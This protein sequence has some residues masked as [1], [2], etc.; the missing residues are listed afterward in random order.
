MDG[1]DQERFGRIVTLH[2]HEVVEPPTLVGR[3]PHDEGGGIPRRQGLQFSV[4]RLTSDSPDLL[5]VQEWL[6]TES[7]Q[8]YAAIREKTKSI[9]EDRVL[10][11]DLPRVVELARTGNN[12]AVNWGM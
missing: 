7:Q 3:Q 6:S 11:D 5:H 9:I 1:N 2:Q 4:R 10:V 8:L 12:I